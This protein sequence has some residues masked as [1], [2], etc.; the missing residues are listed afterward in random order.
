VWRRHYA[1]TGAHPTFSVDGLDQARCTGHLV[2]ADP[3]TVEVACD[4]AY[5]DV[6]ARRRITVDAGVIVDE[7]TVA[8]EQ[9]RRVALHLRP[10]TG[11]TV[12]TGAVT[13]TRWD[14]VATLHGEHTASSPGWFVTRPGPGPADDPQRRRTWVDWTVEDITDVTFRSVYRFVDRSVYSGGM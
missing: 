1:S 7:L 9:P 12:T 8:C 14:G 6:Q 4:T 2:C 5:P 11:L 13:R 10:D 3:R